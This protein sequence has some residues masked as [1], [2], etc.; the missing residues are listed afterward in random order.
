MSLSTPPPPSL[1]LIFIL[2][3]HFILVNVSPFWIGYFPFN[4]F[5]VG[6][7][8]ALPVT[9]RQNID[10]FSFPMSFSIF[11]LPSFPSFTLNWRSYSMIDD[12]IDICSN[13]IRTMYLRVKGKGLSVSAVCCSVYWARLSITAAILSISNSLYSLRN[14]YGRSINN[15]Y[16]KQYAVFSGVG[17]CLS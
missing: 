17:Y 11:F 13:G 16:I 7:W 5:L 10:V 3:Y 1:S 4:F 8:Y 2:S 15:A 12:V 9:W 6:R 14:I